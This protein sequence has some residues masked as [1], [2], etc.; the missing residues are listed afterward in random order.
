[1]IRLR[2]IRYRLNGHMAL[3]D[4]H[5]H[6]HI[7]SSNLNHHPLIIVFVLHGAGFVSMALNATGLG[8]NLALSGKNRPM[9][10]SRKI[11]GTVDHMIWQLRDVSG[12]RDY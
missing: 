1:M 11:G 7:L 9:K 8:T 4:V 12:E 6:F 3:A 10:K 5:I 2:P